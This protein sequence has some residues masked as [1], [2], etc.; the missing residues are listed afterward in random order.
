MRMADDFEHV[1]GR[2]RKWAMILEIA[3]RTNQPVTKAAIA[4]ATEQERR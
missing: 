2:L 1:P 3:D 4:A